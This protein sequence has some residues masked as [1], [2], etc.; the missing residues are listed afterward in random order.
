M[1]VKMH[2]WV[3]GSQIGPTTEIFTEHGKLTALEGV[4][5]LC[6]HG[7]TQTHTDTHTLTH[8]QA[9]WIVEIFV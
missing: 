2:A 4:V 9:V 6:F 7:K 5:R 1:V 8:T 3:V